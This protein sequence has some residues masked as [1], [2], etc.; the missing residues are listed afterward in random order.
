M[1]QVDILAF[2]PHPDDAE[3]GCGGSLI[4]AADRGLRV[5][6]A[7]LSDGEMSSQGT[8]QIR[9][10][11]KDCASEKLGLWKRLSVGLADTEIGA[12]PAQ[13]L[14]IIQLIRDLRPHLVLAPYRHD[15]HPDHE[16]AS[17]LI[18]EACFF[19]GVS[20]IGTGQPHRPEHLF[21]Y[22]I[23]SPLE[24][25]FVIDISNV[26][27]R[28]MEAVNAYRS[29]F[30]PPVDGKASTAI[31]QHGFL[32]FIEAQAIVFGAMVGASYGEAFYLSGPAP[33]NGFPGLENANPSMPGELPPYRVF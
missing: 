2:S 18:K 32:R 17:R 19:A 29:Q 6:I 23:H 16:G 20:K 24:P 28:K 4:L 33:L 15:R 7:D 31:S 22:M 3:L 30:K 12:N 27:E 1:T 13:R 8:P 10:S 14:P 9:K 11:E 25:S 21:Y 5:V 26:W